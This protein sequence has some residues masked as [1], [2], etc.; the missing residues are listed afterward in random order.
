MSNNL[1]RMKIDG[2]QDLEKALQELGDAKAI[3]R[4]IKAALMEAAEPTARMARSLAPRKTGRMAEGVDVST[5]LS[6]R[7]KSGRGGHVRARG[8]FDPFAAFVYIGAH[9]TGPAVL[10]EFGTQKRHTKSG[11]STG[12]MPAKPFMRPAWEAGKD[13][14]LRDLQRYL[15]VTIEKEAKRLARRQ[16]RLLAKGSK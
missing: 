9:P 11:K 10:A 12:A 16:A 4:T 2:F 3:K 13:Q 5:T 14:I 1:L 6:R 15:W 8:H 7:Q